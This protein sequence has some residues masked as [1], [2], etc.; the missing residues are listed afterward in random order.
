MKRIYILLAV[1]AGLSVKHTAIAQ[2]F[3]ICQQGNVSTAQELTFSDGGTTVNGQYATTDIDSITLDVPALRFVG[4]DV[5]LLPSYC[6]HGA[7]YKTHTGTLITTAPTGDGRL[8]QMLQFFKQ[9]GLNTLRVR[10]FVNPANA[11]STDKGQGVCQ[12]LAYVTRLAKAIKAEGL[13]LLLDFHYSDSWADP[14]KQWT[15]GEWLSLDDESLG[16]KLYDYTKDCLETLV[17]AG[18][19]PD[20]IQTGNEI[21]YGMLWGAQGS[22]RNRCYASSD[23]NWPRFTTLLKQAGRA[24]REVCPRA[25]IILHT[26]R[27]PNVG[28]LTDF[29]RRMNLAA[30]DY[31]IIGLSYY[32]YYHGTLAKLEAAVKQMKQSYPGKKVHIVETGYC[33]QYGITVEG[34][35]YDYSSQ[36]PYT[37]EGQRQFAAAL[38]STLKRNDNVSGL[39]W[40]MCEANEY[41]LNWSTNRVTDSWYN[42]SLFSNS[43]GQACSALQEL[44]NFR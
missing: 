21:S 32:S 42:A 40:W 10:L 9:Q 38:V 25:K 22:S 15:P 34:S 1:L 2:Q 27:V 16:R 37:D 33:S 30:V 43:T 11:S 3:Y 12:D 7:Q 13:L 20:F 6:D 23:A 31:D 44:K 19:V 18:A 39:S 14:A 24:C 29:Y 26:E 41:G 17:Q 4:G 8:K 35:G 28:T 5:S 36:Y